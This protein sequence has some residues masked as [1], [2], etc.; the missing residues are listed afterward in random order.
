[1]IKNEMLVI[2][3]RVLAVIEKYNLKDIVFTSKM[4]ANCTKENMTIDLSSLLDK[5]VEQCKALQI[6]KT[7]YN[8]EDETLA[9][10]RIAR[11]AKK[12]S[13]DIVIARRLLKIANV[14]RIIS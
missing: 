8:K 14:E 3:T 12:D 11:H 2:K 5:T 13:D 10:A 6:K 9:L 1:M 7:F 4:F